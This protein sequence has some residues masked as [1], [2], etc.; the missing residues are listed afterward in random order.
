MELGKMSLQ[1]LQAQGWVTATRELSHQIGWGYKILQ[2][3]NLVG[4]M[5]MSSSIW[6]QKQL[7]DPE[8]QKR[9]FSRFV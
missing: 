2:Y 4:C 5:A 3:N 8:T 1:E 6:S 9:L 7:E